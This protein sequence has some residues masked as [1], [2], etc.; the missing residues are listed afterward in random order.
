MANKCRNDS[1]SDTVNT[2]FY[3]QYNLF[4]INLV[5]LVLV[6]RW[7]ESAIGSILSSPSFTIINLVSR[8]IPPQHH[9]SYGH[10]LV[11]STYNPIYTASTWAMP[12]TS[13]G[14]TVGMLFLVTLTVLYGWR[15]CWDVTRW[16]PSR[17][18]VGDVIFDPLR[19]NPYGSLRRF[20]L[21]VQHH[22]RK[23]LK[24]G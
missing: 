3:G 11:I 13:F 16:C 12:A 10:L 21:F 8:W 24:K 6:S 14:I 1:Y 7:I 9:Y 5:S 18:F 23:W 22:C 19:A 15:L 17:G 4:T 2:N 20:L